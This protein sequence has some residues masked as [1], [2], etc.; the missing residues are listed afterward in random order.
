MIKIIIIVIIIIVI[1]KG[2]FQ[3]G[4]FSA[5]STTVNHHIVKE[6][7]PLHIGNFIQQ[8]LGYD[9]FFN[10]QNS[11]TTPNTCIWRE[12]IIIAIS[13]TRSW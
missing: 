9:F 10:I 13:F 6:S 12:I 11:C 7:K 5:A 1:I 3:P 2:L 4:D 8:H